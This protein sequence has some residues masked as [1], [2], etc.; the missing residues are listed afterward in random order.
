MPGRDGITTAEVMG[1]SSL[2]SAVVMLSISDD[3]H[4]RVQTQEQQG[5]WRG[6]GRE[7]CYERGSLKLRSS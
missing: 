4:T 5:F 3:V 1:S 6:V 2:Q 7:R